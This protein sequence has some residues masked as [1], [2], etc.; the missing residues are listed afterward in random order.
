MR[1][2]WDLG[3]SM[4]DLWEKEL[5]QV[6]LHGFQILSI[7]MSSNLKNLHT[8]YK[9]K[10][11]WASYWYFDQWNYVVCL[12]SL[13]TNLSYPSLKTSTIP[14]IFQIVPFLCSCHGHVCVFTDVLSSCCVWVCAQIS[15]LFEKITFRDVEKDQSWRGLVALSE[16]TCSVL[17]TYHAANNHP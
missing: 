16:D 2:V 1:E 6:S 14:Y 7:F 12:Y 11:Q 4:V 15:S 17:N 3:I 13:L 5:F 8:A 10:K 9:F